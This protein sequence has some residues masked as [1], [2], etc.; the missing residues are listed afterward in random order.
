MHIAIFTDYY[1]PTLGGIQT[2]IKAQKEALEKKGHRV[3]VFCPGHIPSNDPNVV[4]LPTLKLFKPDGYSVA[5]TTKKVIEAARKGIVMLKDI[6]I[7]HSHS[8]MAAGVAGLIV[9]KELGIPSVQSMHGRE[10]VYASKVLPLP[11][12]FSAILTKLHSKHISHKDVLISRKGPQS[13]TITARRMWRLMVSHANYADQVIVPSYHFAKK[14]QYYGL[15]KPTII[16]S[17]GLEQSV[18]RKIG[19][20]ERRKYSRNSKLKIM[21]CGR[22]SPEKRPLEFL[23]AI[24]KLKFDYVVDLYGEGVA[25]KKVLKSVAMKNLSGRVV[26]RGGVTQQ[27][28]LDEM[29]NHHCLVYTSFDFDNQPMVLLE[30]I[31]TGLPVIYCDP[32]LSETIPSGGSILSSSSS[33]TQ[34]AHAINEVHSSPSKIYNMSKSML[35]N[36]ECIKQINQINSLISLYKNLADKKH[37]KSL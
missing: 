17:N 2:S 28:L 23:Q 35:E 1:L 4:I 16:L 34:I 33:P 6:D 27:R 19:R 5:G 20:P 24:E 10:D 13:K 36:T 9:A 22:V 11:G 31:A 8:D 18:L 21:W 3:T 12:L 32:D 7:V 15:T 26:V 14:L 30:A 25:L 37:I 29:K